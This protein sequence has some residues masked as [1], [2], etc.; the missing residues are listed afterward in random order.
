MYHQNQHLRLLKLHWNYPKKTD[1]LEET[2]V[3]KVPNASTDTI[4][5]S[6]T[7]WHFGSPVPSIHKKGSF[8][9]G[10]ATIDER[11][12]DNSPLQSF[13][14]TSN[15]FSDPLAQIEASEGE[16]QVKLFLG[17]HFDPKSMLI[18]DSDDPLSSVVFA[19]EPHSSG[20]ILFDPS[21][22]GPELE[23]F[24]DGFLTAEV[25]LS[26]IEYVNDDTAP[27]KIDGSLREMVSYFAL[28]G[29]AYQGDTLNIPQDEFSGA[30]IYKWL[31]DGVAIEGADQSSY[32]L[33][34]FDVDTHISV[35]VE[36]EN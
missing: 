35:L 24:P 21:M 15:E 18:Y 1:V 11:S 3:F 12:F 23:L 28:A 31:R 33:S 9:I 4:D 10:F 29:T 27:L 2:V 26:G 13:Q 36:I 34:Q 22:F 19:Y 16:A 14:V 7:D 32:T 20:V 6:F 17:D 30:V 5:I 8:E 25:N